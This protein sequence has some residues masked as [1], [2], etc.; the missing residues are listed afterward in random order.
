MHELILNHSKPNKMFSPT[1]ENNTI[2]F[3][4]FIE[5]LHQFK[6][7]N[8]RNLD[9]MHKYWSVRMAKKNEYLFTKDLK[10]EGFSI[11]IKGAVKLVATYKEK[12]IVF[13][14]LTEGSFIEI[15][16]EDIDS[17]FSGYSAQCTEPTIL[18][19][20]SRH[21]MRN[22][23]NEYPFFSNFF[24]E[25]KT[26]AARDLKSRMMSIRVLTAKE[27][28]E[29][30]C[31]GYPHLLNHFALQDIASYLGIQAETLSRIRSASLKK[32]S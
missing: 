9:S 15:K 27:R 19:T 10:I 30:I 23:I 5:Y 12:D 32:A 3:S 25:Q 22:L 26:Q 11:I 21:H 4:H 7:F 1:Y 31:Y 2:I 14:L 13:D 17:H 28:Y 16:N 6:N 18:M 29:E 8:D 24:A 20:I